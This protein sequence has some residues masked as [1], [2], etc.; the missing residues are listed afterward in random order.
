METGSRPAIALPLKRLIHLFTV[1]L[2]Y[3]RL[4]CKDTAGRREHIPG[5]DSRSLGSGSPSS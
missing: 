1:H 3:S 5:K 2:D 4:A